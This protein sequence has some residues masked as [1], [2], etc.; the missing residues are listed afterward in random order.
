MTEM[1]LFHSYASGILSR[2]SDLWMG[3]RRGVL[4]TAIHALT[5]QST[6][7]RCVRAGPHA[8]N[9]ATCHRRD[10]RVSVYT[11]RRR[12]KLLMRGRSPLASLE[13]ASPY[14]PRHH[15]WG[16]RSDRARSGLGW[17]RSALEP[18]LSRFSAVSL[19]LDP[20]KARHEPPKGR[21]ARSSA[22]RRARLVS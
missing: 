12:C 10:A 13:R 16:G 17:R 21:Q 22:S 20:L 19:A 15:E 9:S 11:R 1:S 3:G 14:P 8:C 2:R 5:F 6:H 4:C 18:F 7:L